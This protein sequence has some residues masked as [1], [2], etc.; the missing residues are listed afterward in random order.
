MADEDEGLI[1]RVQSTH[2]PAGVRLRPIGGHEEAISIE[3]LRVEPSPYGQ[4][5]FARIGGRAVDGDGLEAA[6]VHGDVLDSA[7]QAEE[8]PR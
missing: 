4:K 7:D 6:G 5:A 8:R 1:R 2:D 3:H